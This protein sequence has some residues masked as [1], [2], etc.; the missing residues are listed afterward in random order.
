MS[1]PIVKLYHLADVGRLVT[2]Q[3]A[4]LPPFSLWSALYGGGGFG[5]VKLPDPLT[6]R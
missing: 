4:C 2:D 5:F 3:R 1:S 6:N